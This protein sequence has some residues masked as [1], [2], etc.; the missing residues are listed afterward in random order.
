[1]KQC[2]RSASTFQLFII[3]IIIYLSIK[4]YTITMISYRYLRFSLD[5][6]IDVLIHNTYLSF[7][8]SARWL[9]RILLYSI[10]TRWDN[11]ATNRV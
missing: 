7:M 3:H 4:V 1:L 10:V 9:C 6:T 8:N 11:W 2:S 5:W